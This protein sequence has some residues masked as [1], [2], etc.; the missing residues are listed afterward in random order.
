MKI[1]YTEYFQKSKVFLYPLLGLRKGLE[2]VPA[3][4][5]IC[6]DKL[7]DTK[8]YKLI[9]VYETEKTVDFKNF[10]LKHL[11]NHSLLDFYYDF[12]NK[13]AYVFDMKTYKHDHM[14]FAKGHYSKI[15][16]GTKNKILQYFGSKGKASDYIE[17]FL[18]PSG[19][20]EVYAESLGVNV[21]LIKEVYEVCSKPDIV[22]ETLCEKIPEDLQF[23]KDKFISL[24]QNQ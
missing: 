23:L 21:E 9:C 22:K 2:Y 8:D 10:E 1:V 12:G 19:F 4:T 6:W 7:F 17:S 18:N 13:Q 14:M 15:S 16:I 3:D 5:Y 11:K 24:K 20:H